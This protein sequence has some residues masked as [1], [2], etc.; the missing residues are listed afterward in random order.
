MISKTK[1]LWY[2]HETKGTIP[3]TGSSQPLKGLDDQQGKHQY[4]NRNVITQ[5]LGLR[6]MDQPSN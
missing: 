5:Y 2:I 3:I 4:K 6:K 1:S